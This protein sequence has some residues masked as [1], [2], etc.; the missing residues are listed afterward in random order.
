MIKVTILPNN[1]ISV[2]E[3]TVS[4]GVLFDKIGF[5]FPE[6]WNGFSKTA[7]FS[8]ENEKTV[9]V[10]LNENNPLCTGEDECYIPF[11]VLQHPGFYISVFGV[12]GDS[13][14]TSTKEF[15]NVSESGYALGDKPEEPTQD[16]YQQLVNLA[17]NTLQIANSVR[18]DADNGL[19]NG[20]AGPKG[21][22]GEQGPKG[23]KGEK[24][25]CGE[26]GIIE[27]VDTVYN[28]ESSNAQ[29]GIAVAQ[30]IEESLGMVK[31]RLS[32]Y[33]SITGEE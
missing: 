30:A 21:D 1:H 28:G 23:E 2:K 11:E 15:V 26:P 32:D 4:D 13:K 25:D 33:F 6:N 31:N 3:S 19:F 16:Q 7:V 20:A 29:S 5:L 12:M 22:T 8:L 9:S 17:E 10:V 24:G 27:N 14:A 18:L